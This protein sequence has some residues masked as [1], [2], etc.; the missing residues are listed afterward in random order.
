MI[1]L[2]KAHFRLKE[3][4]EAYQ[5][6]EKQPFFFRKGLFLSGQ[7]FTIIGNR[8]YFVTYLH[9]LELFRLTV[10]SFQEVQVN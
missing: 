2:E 3:K 5:S 8:K 10:D 7:W 1:P 9:E 6:L 4:F